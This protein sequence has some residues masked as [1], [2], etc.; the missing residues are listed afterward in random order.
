MCSSDLHGW[1]AA[2]FS[3][4]NIDVQGHEVEALEGAGALLRVVDA[5]LIEL[6]Q[7][8]RYAEGADPEAVQNLLDPLPDGIEKLDDKTASDHLPVWMEFA[9]AVAEPITIS[10]ALLPDG[11]ISL[12]WNGQIGQQYEVQSSPDFLTWTS[13]AGGLTAG[14]TANHW[15]IKAVDP[16]LFFRVNERTT[17]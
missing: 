7:R 13:A 16:F 6:N 17:R 11:V 9:L 10:A 14:T 2:D 4:L 15:Q 1:S 8:Q 12:S 3:L 5:V